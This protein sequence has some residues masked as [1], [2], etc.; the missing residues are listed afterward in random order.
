MNHAGRA[1]VGDYRA[2]MA[3]LKSIAGPHGLRRRRQDARV[4]AS[5]SGATVVPAQDGHTDAA[6]VDTQQRCAGCHA[7]TFSPAQCLKT[8]IYEALPMYSSLPVIVFVE[9]VLGR[10]SVGAAL[11]LSRNRMLYLKSDPLFPLPAQIL[12]Y[13]LPRLTRR[14]RTLAGAGPPRAGLKR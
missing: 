9:C 12:L 7:T 4:L 8:F 11:S 6:T 1:P 14:R 10:R 3:T 2:D 5:T 13:L